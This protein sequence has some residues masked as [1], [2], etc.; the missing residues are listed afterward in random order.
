MITVYS[1][2]LD[3]LVRRA[4]TLVFA[5]HPELSVDAFTWLSL[6]SNGRREA[7]PSSDIDTAVA[8]DEG[9]RRQRS[10]LPAGLRRGPRLLARAGVS[11]DHHGATAAHPAFA[12][13]NDQWRAAGQEWLSAP[14]KNK[15]AMMTSLLVDGRAIH[16]DPG[17]P[18]VTG[19]F[20][21]LRRHPG[22][23]RLLLQESL[24]HR[25]RMRSVLDVLARRGR[26]FDIKAGAMLPV[27]NMAG[28][29]PSAWGRRPCRPPNG[30]GRRPVRRCS[31]PTGRP[32]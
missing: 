23:M 24:S 28:G 13:T 26:L 21:E 19:V 27:V 15:G 16:G 18:A 5:A 9:C 32:T 4:I 20:A 17:L 30:S 6:G 10:T 11:G 1:T 2:L 22:T 29:P 31:R 3:T 8:F 7:M 14:G 25:A 12:R